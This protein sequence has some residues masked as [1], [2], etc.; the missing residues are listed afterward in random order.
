MY[1]MV[2]KGPTLSYV[3]PKSTS[4]KRGGAVPQ[5]L[6]LGLQSEGWEPH[7]ICKCSPSNGDGGREEPM[8]AG[9]S[10]PGRQLQGFPDSIPTLALCLL[11]DTSSLLPAYLRHICL[12][13]ES[14]PWMSRVLHTHYGKLFLRII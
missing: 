11:K 4:S 8:G 5:L 13:H 10:S 3:H 12:E 14:L 1:A 9:G 6:Q 7:Q 2:G